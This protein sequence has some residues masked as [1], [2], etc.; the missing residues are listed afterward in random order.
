M[1]Q[2]EEIKEYPG[3]AAGWGALKA[4]T[5]SWLGSENGFRNL[6]AMLKTNQNGGFDCPGC[7]WGES[8]E[9]G[10]VNFCEN[11][12]K[13]VNWEATSRLV[14][15]EFFAQYSVS[16]LSKQTDYWL[17]Y[18]GRLSHPM[19]YD[20]QTD[21]YVEISWEDAFALVG[22]HLNALQSPDEAEF[23]TSGRASNEAAFLYQ[24]F[25]RA[26]GTNNFPD[27]SNMCHEASAIG[28][29]DS[30][31]VGKGT[32]VFKDLE[33]ADA[34]FVIGQNPGTNHPRMLE[35]LREAVKRGAQVICLNPLKERGLERFQNPQLPIEMLSNG[36]EPTSSAY[37]RPALGG[38]MAV[39]RGMAKFLLQWDRQA[40]AQGDAPVLD[41][42][43]I[44]EHTNGIEEYLSAVE[45]TS[46]EHITQQSGLSLE[47]IEVLARMYR[48]AERVVMC[49]A[50]GL[51]QHRHSVFTI[52]EVVNLQLLRGN[53]GK[54]GAGLSPVRGHSNVQGDRTMGINEKPPQFLLDALEK[55]FQFKAPR[56]HGH[57]AVLA[58]KAMEEKRAKVFVGLGGNFAQATPDTPRT[59][60]AM[61]NC[62]LTVHIATKL[63]RSHLVT[64]HDALILPCL[65]RTE[66]D[67]QANGPQ[68]V[69]VEDTFSMVH[70]SYGQLKPRSPHL[71][72]EAAILAGIA[73]ATLGNFP[74]DWDW[75]IADY[76]H[77]RDLI[78]DT[79]PGFQNFN[80]RVQNPGGFYLGNSAARRE[81]NTA[82]GKAQ[83]SAT[84][85]PEQLVNENVTQRGDKPD[86]ILQTLRSHDQYNTTLYG[87]DDRYRG[88]FGRRDVV[89]ANEEDIRRLGF[90]PGD[91]VDLVTLWDD[92]LERRVNGFELVA[93]DV[94]AGQAAAY[95]PETNPLV[96]LDS[97]GERTFTPT[98]KF[99]AI[100][101]EKAKPSIIIPATVL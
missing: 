86:L 12:A 25:V 47:E 48:R 20:A 54:P 93:Y 44:R 66:I 52:Q 11:G 68:G 34:I 29:F 3:P 7:A 41:H 90:E 16:E 56:T 39:F 24:L 17:E 63:N 97:Y 18:Q 89:F 98:S 6:R 8:P 99:V 65:G 58:I 94:P 49:W 60:A 96:P 85:L 1:N 53:V 87:L 9:N 50:M 72:S 46:W 69:T 14:D 76:R 35:P 37:F 28:M 23:Y 31:G 32:V 55:R 40:Q 73:K 27:C 80:Q 71:R 4:V 42:D 36:S 62:E 64:G 57:N 100:K 83:F 45:Q 59:H 15:P 67:M 70:L 51:T 5:K 19:R 75:A 79:I 74:I 22:K 38:D 61:R 81:W 26:F 21:H 88:V 2:K 95:Y 84:T 101:L 78:A 82:S 91:R 10:M 77:I 92:G 33:L 13:A 43:F 30:I